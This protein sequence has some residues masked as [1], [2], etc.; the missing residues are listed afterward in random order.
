MLPDR[1]KEVEERI[2][3]YVKNS[4]VRKIFKS[5]SWNTTTD[6][7]TEFR[8]I[9]INSITNK[10]WFVEMPDQSYWNWKPIPHTY[11][12]SVEEGEIKFVVEKILSSIPNQNKL[13]HAIEGDD[14]LEAKEFG[15][16]ID[17]A[18]S[19]LSGTNLIMTNFKDYTNFFWLDKKRFKFDQPQK[20]KYIIGNYD[21]IDIFVSRMLP[22][23]KTILLNTDQIGEFI[24]KKEIT[25]NLSEISDKERPQIKETLNLPE[26]DINNRVRMQIEEVIQ[27][28][29]K[30]PDYSILVENLNEKTK[31]GEK[32]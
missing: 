32:K 11:A 25:A 30:K 3:A 4:I 23:G 19:R 8:K 29:V 6:A 13:S 28:V 21:N 17:L 16:L 10:E 2:I 12:E 5:R 18:M 24:I 15:K 1:K 26:E 9:G 14:Y 22:R 27:F 31:K 7:Q 20:D